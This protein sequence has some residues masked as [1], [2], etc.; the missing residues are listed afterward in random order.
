MWSIGC[1]SAPSAGLEPAHCG[2]GSWVPMRSIGRRSAP[3]AGLEPA[4]TLGREWGADAGASAVGRRPRQDSNLRTRLA[5]ELWCRCG[6]SAVGRRPRQDS[7]LRTRLRRPMLY[8]LSYEGGGWTMPG[9]TLG[10]RASVALIRPAAAERRPDT[11]LHL[12]PEPQK[13]A[14]ALLDA[15][16]TGGE[17]RSVARSAAA[18]RAESRSASSSLPPLES[19]RGRDTSRGAWPGAVQDAGAARSRRRRAALSASAARSCRRSSR[20]CWFERTRSCRLIG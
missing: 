6:A 19:T 11:C 17:P 12:A 15:T 18:P 5:R 9:S 10:G 3:S 7:N 20:S 1:R 4:H 16:W 2:A 8:P 13:T 14:I